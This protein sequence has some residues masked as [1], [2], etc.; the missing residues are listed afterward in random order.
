MGRFTLNPTSLN[1]LAD[2]DIASLA[3]GLFILLPSL[4]ILIF[5]PP[6]VRFT[7]MNWTDG[8][9]GRTSQGSQDEQHFHFPLHRNPR[10]YLHRKRHI[11]L[12]YI[13]SDSISRL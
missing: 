6:R 13:L 11:I 3:W 7:S 12:G 1:F 8:W 9:K 2:I 10:Q 4:I 5:S